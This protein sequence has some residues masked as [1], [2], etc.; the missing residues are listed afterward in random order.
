MN[1]ITH[2]LVS[3]TVAESTGLEKRD[4]A[5]VTWSGVLP[6]LDGFGVIIDVGNRLMGRPETHYYEVYHHYL[7][8]SLAAGVLFAVIIAIAG[9]NKTKAALLALIAFHLH[10]FCDIVGSRGSNPLDI[11]TV[12]YLIPFSDSLIL[13]WD[14]QWPLTSWQNTTVTI[15]LMGWILARAV[16]QGHSPVGIFSTRADAVFVATLQERW[17]R[18]PRGNDG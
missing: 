14:G 17:K 4:R 9:V 18:L 11:W 12:S 1:T 5:L 7:G 16:T 3:W 10:L 2:F 13:E 15:L 8:H 6:D